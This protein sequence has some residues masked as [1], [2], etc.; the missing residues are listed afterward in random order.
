MTHYLIQ[1]AYTPESWKTQVQSQ[2]DVAERIRPMMDS[3]GGKIGTIFYAFGEYDLIAL[4]EFPNDE[5]AAAFSLAA[6]AGGAVKG[7]KTTPLMTVEQGRR[8]M[9]AAAEAGSRYRAPIGTG[10]MRETVPR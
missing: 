3:L 8:A 6:N 10:T 1:V 5:A 4:A 7:I 2:E 9:K